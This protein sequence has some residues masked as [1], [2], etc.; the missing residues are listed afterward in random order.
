MAS[1]NVNC[2]IEERASL[3]VLLTPGVGLV[4]PLVFDKQ[5]LIG[6]QAVFELRRLNTHYIVYL[7]Q[8]IEG[9]AQNFSHEGSFYAGYHDK[10]CE[11][12][13]LI[14]VPAEHKQK[15][16]KS[17]GQPITSPMDG[18]FYLKSSPT[19][20]PFVEIGKPIEPGQT[21]GLIEVMKCFYPVKYQGS[22]PAK[23]LSILVNNASPVSAGTE[24]FL[25]AEL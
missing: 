10:F 14:S 4:K 6:G 15:E 7:P 23:L 19:A 9:I 21:I 12:A 18:M 20:A 16:A 1:I 13:E 22:K 8:D 25:T 5:P 17:K 3:K 2:E 24:V 11:L